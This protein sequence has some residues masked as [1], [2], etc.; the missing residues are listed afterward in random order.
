MLLLECE[1]SDSDASV[2]WSKNKRYLT[3]SARVK[4]EKLGC[5]QRLIID[6]ALLEDTGHYVCETADERSR[7]ITNVIVKSNLDLFY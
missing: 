3:N 4:I 6:N 1:I 2:K 5:I 7:S